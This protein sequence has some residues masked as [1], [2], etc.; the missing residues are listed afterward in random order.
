MANRR[1]AAY[2]TSST[3]FGQ[4]KNAWQCLQY[5]TECR[6]NAPYIGIH[7]TVRPMKMVLQSQNSL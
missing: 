6:T 3:K 5:T 2:R 7:Y 4:Y 1:I